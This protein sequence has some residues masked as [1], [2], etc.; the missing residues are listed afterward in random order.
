MSGGPTNLSLSN[1]ILLTNKWNQVF[2]VI[3]KSRNLLQRQTKMDSLIR[4]RE[5]HARQRNCLE[6]QKEGYVCFLLLA[7]RRFAGMQALKKFSKKEIY[8]L[9]HKDVLEHLMFKD[10]ND[11]GRTIIHHHACPN[12]GDALLQTC[13][14]LVKCSLRHSANL[15]LSSS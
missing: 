11:S 4:N 2:L 1:N 15:V 5:L 9:D 3:Q 6:K 13:P 12:V 7:I 8:G 10:E 14:N